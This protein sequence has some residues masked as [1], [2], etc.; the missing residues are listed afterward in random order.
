MTSLDDA[1][2]LLQAAYGRPMPLP[3]R[4]AWIKTSGA[5][6]TSRTAGRRENCVCLRRNSDQRFEKVSA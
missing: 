6:G 1:Q 3:G 4:E 2:E 5:G